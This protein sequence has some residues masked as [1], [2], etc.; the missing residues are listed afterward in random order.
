[1][2]IRAKP[3]HEAKLRDLARAADIFT[4]AHI[5]VSGLLLKRKFINNKNIFEI[6]SAGGSARDAA[7]MIVHI[8]RREQQQRDTLNLRFSARKRVT[9]TAESDFPAEND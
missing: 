8:L 6:V 2:R 4:V 1:M 7:Q 9:S 3:Q 5:A